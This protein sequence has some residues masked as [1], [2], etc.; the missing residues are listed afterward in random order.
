MRTEDKS[1][2]LALDKFQRENTGSFI[3]S[4]SGARIG[5]DY[6]AISIEDMAVSL[7]RLCRFAGHC[8]RFWPVLLHIFVVYDLV[9][10]E[11]KVGAMLH[12]GGEPLIGDIPTPF[13]IPEMKSL[14]NRLLMQV[15]NTHLTDEQKLSWVNGGYARIKAADNEAF[16]G[17][18]WTVGS[19]A[20]RTLV[21]NRSRRAENLVKMYMKEYPVDE[22]LRPD[23]TAIIEFIRRAK[24]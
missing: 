5:L 24:A 6:P 7:G 15:L 1:S 21:P 17:E 14:E 19:K 12:E 22:C 20:L 8:L 11:D 13:K 2:E 23:G 16:V 10:E 3:F 4:H 9:C 18:V